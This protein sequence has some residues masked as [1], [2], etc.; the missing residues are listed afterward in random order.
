MQYL[1]LVGLPILGGMFLTFYA[2]TKVNVINME[3]F[4]LTLLCMHT[5]IWLSCSLC[6]TLMMP[7]R[8]STKLS[9]YEGKL[10][11]QRS[12]IKSDEKNMAKKK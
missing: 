11:M 4:T 7:R 5:E 2:G 8:S 12:V 3:S 1:C 9:N 6:S 10:H